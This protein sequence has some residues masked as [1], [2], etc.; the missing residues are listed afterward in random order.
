MADTVRLGFVGTGGIANHHLGRLKEIEGVQIVAL[1]DVVADR[2]KDATAKWGGK[3]YTDYSQMIATESLDGLYVCIPPFAHADAEILAARKGVHLFVEKPVVLDLDLGKRIRDEVEKAGIIT[4]VG[5][6]MR[7][8][9]AADAARAFL[10][11]KKVGMVAC[12]RWGGIPGG[13]THWWRVMDKSGGQLHEMA[14]H[15]L[16]MIRFLAGEI[17]EVYKKEG[18]MINTDQENFTVPDAEVVTLQFAGGG[19]GYISTSCAL[20]NGGHQGRLEILAEGHLLLRYGRELQV[21]PEGAAA[22]SVSPEPVPSIDEAFVQ[23]IRTGNRSLVRSPYGD[24]LRSAAVTIAANQS[25]REGKPVAV[26]A[27]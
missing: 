1:C 5:Y 21:I 2:V 20:V 18:R 10:K 3:P 22:I 11:G 17:S 14:T 7:Y 19:V 12:D 24:G 13:P 4:S 8:S 6:G 15:Q 26:P 23:A 16:D 25:A 9:A 27:V